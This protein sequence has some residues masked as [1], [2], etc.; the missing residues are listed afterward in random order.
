MLST[1]SC[2]ASLLVCFPSLP[3]LSRCP[4]FPL[5]VPTLFIRLLF[6]IIYYVLFITIYD[7]LLLCITS[8]ITPPNNNRPCARSGIMVAI[9]LTDLLFIIHCLLSFIIIY[10]YLLLFITS[11]ITPPN[12]NRPRARSGIMVAI[13]LTDLLPAA[14]HYERNHALV[15]GAALLGMFVMALSLVFFVL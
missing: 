5:P 15:S 3:S 13:S 7:F 6:I 8:C 4:P 11:H 14:F 9:S 10:D 1:A 12:N 2:L